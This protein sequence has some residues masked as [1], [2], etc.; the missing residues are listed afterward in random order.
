MNHHPEQLNGETNLL[1]QIEDHLRML[2]SRTTFFTPPFPVTLFEIPL[3]VKKACCFETF[4]LVLK[5][6]IE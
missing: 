1:R 2:P 6:N 3:F 5:V 4:G